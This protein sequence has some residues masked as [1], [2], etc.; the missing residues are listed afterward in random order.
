VKYLKNIPY[1]I[2]FLAMCAILLMI[3]EWQHLIIF[4]IVGGGIVYLFQ[5][6][7][8]SIVDV[9]KYNNVKIASLTNIPLRL[10]ILDKVKNF[11]GIYHPQI[12]TFE[13]NKSY[14]VGRA[15]KKN[16]IFL[17]DKSK[18]VSRWH[19][20]IDYEGSHLF[21]TDLG[22]A[23]GT[24]INEVKIAPNVKTPLKVQDELKIANAH[25]RYKRA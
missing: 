4:F 1:V 5:Q 6:R 20:V 11:F 7:Q 17:Y 24:Y 21:V 18:Q 15:F 13:D 9:T 25:F 16:D 22:S 8:N 2:V 10:T 3:F 19:L 14:R 23:N 12:L